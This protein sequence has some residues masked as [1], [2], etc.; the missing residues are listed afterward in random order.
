MGIILHL[1]SQGANIKRLKG[2]KWCFWHLSGRGQGC[3]KVPYK[4]QGSLYDKEYCPKMLVVLPVGNHAL[5]SNSA[6]SVSCSVM[7]DSL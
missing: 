1:H 2:Q 7:F 5:D 4:A 6:E 3:C